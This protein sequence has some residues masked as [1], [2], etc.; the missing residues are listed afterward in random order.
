[1]QE[2]RLTFSDNNG[3]LLQHLFHASFYSSHSS[4]S[5]SHTI[6]ISYWRIAPKQLTRNDWHPTKKKEI[7][8]GRKKKKSPKTKMM[9]N[10]SCWNVWCC[11]IFLVELQEHCNS[12]LYGFLTI[13]LH[14][15]HLLWQFIFRSHFPFL[16]LFVH[17][18]DTYIWFV[19]HSLSLSF[20]LSFRLFNKQNGF[21]WFP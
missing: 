14:I 2:I 21:R 20:S 7:R 17:A 11:N 16:M 9:K 18:V 15:H 5:F 12:F 1:M 19:F 3:L 13:F 6:K 8:N 4:T 10:M